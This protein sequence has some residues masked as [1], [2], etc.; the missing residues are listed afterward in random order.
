VIEKP[1]TSKCDRCK[2][3]KVIAHVLEASFGGRELLYCEPC[4]LWIDA[5][6]RFQKGS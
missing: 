4:W 2:E 5:G 6:V 1:N 3:Q